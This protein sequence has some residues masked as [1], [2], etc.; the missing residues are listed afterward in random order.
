MDALNTSAS[1]GRVLPDTLQH[2]RPV[3]IDDLV[4]IAPVLLHSKSRPVTRAWSGDL[5]S[6][7]ICVRGQS[8]PADRTDDLDWRRSAIG[9][10]PIFRASAMRTRSA[11]DRAAI[12]RMILPRWI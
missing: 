3:V 8:A 1:A 12:F 6:T 4:R 2:L 11:K 9:R 7:R 5:T 10:S